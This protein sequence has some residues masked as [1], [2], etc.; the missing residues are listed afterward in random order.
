MALRAG[1]QHISSAIF[2][3]LALASVA[4]AQT[5]SVGGAEKLSYGVDAGIGETDNVA[6]APT[7]KIS[8]TITTVEVDVD[9]RHRSRRL[10]VDAKGN[11]TDFDYLEGAFG[12]QLLG[13]DDP[14]FVQI[15][16]EVHGNSWRY[17]PQPMH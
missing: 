6:L 16:S 17:A 2:S 10:D 12:N 3:V 9:V 15:E 13:R 11:F 7:R 5:S 4:N 8:Q 14:F 1:V